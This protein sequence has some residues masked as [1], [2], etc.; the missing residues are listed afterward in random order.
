MSTNQGPQM[1]R[2]PARLKIKRDSKAIVIHKIGITKLDAFKRGCPAQAH[3]PPT[4]LIDYIVIIARDTTC[5]SL[6]LQARF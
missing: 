6:A 5:Y 1:E 4:L 3:R 2:D